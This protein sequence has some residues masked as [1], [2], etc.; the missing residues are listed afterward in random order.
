[1]RPISHTCTADVPPGMVCD[2]PCAACEADAGAMSARFIRDAMDRIEPAI[3]WQS[4]TPAQVF[5]LAAAMPKTLGPWEYEVPTFGDPGEEWARRQPKYNGCR[6]LQAR[7][8]VTQRGDVSW[9][10]GMG[11][12]VVATVEEAKRAADER[13]VSDRWMLVSD[14]GAGT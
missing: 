6:I 3:F 13:L 10:A 14:A 5:A 12:G 7:V 4:L 2:I 11:S 1:M 9:S 8:K